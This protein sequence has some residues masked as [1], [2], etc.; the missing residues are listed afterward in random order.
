M[1]LAL[2]LLLLVRLPMPGLLL[3][4]RALHR[5]TGSPGPPTPPIDL[6]TFAGLM[7]QKEALPDWGGEASLILEYK[8]ARL[9]DDIGPKRYR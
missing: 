7:S 3:L 8:R 5:R 4:W 9:L 1:L 2:L 6:A